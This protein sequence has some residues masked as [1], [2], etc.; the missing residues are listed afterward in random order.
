MI[1]LDYEDVAGVESLA[2]YTYYGF[3]II[4]NQSTYI[5]NKTKSFDEK[6]TK[7]AQ[8]SNDDDFENR[9]ARTR[10]KPRE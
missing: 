4:Q 6:T 9:C 5:E 1:G 8:M 3:H 7:N 2:I 10:N